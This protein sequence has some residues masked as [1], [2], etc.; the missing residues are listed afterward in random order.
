MHA[1]A[2]LTAAAVECSS[3]WLSP[4]VTGKKSV[5]PRKMYKG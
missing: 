5:L 1:G 2:E 3:K 4:D